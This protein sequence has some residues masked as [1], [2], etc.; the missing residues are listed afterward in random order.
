MSRQA[1]SIALL[2]LAIASAL[3]GSAVLRA[4]DSGQAPEPYTGDIRQRD[5]RA[6]ELLAAL[7]A[8]TP[9]PAELRLRYSGTRGDYLAFY[10]IEGR[11]IMYR[12]REDRFD[13]RAEKRIEDLI[14][15]QAYRVSGRFT[16][17]LVDGVFY[18]EDSE[19]YRDARNDA[20]ALLAYE[21]QQAVSL[22]LEQIL[23]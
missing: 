17:V 19:R 11:D 6:A 12:Y 23:Y 21:Y 8:G 3:A 14:A 16:G 2:A 9:P 20:K 7:R 13:R 15:G 10:D 5:P 1:H 18:A 22:R 4:R